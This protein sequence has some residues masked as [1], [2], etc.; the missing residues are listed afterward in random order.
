MILCFDTLFCLHLYY[1]FANIP[2]TRDYIHPV[3]D[4][5]YEILKEIAEGTFSKEKTREEKSAAVKFWRNR[6]FKMVNGKLYF[7]ERE[8]WHCN[9]I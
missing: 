3:C 2:T 4:S 6:K 8:V 7:G 5:D 9:Y 1:I